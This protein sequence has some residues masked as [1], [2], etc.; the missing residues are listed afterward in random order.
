MPGYQA[1]DSTLPAAGSTRISVS[2]L[3]PGGQ[4]RHHREPDRR[5]CPYNSSRLPCMPI[6]PKYL[7]TFGPGAQTYRAFAVLTPLIRARQDS[8]AI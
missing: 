1:A 4:A 2:R 3:P 6:H 8:L 5:L 7:K